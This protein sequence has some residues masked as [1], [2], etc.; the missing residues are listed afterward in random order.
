M[1]DLNV[2]EYN[3]ALESILRQEAEKCRGYAWLHN[4]CEAIY[5]RYHNTLLIPTIILSTITGATSMSS[6]SLFAG[7]EKSASVGLGAVAILVGILNTLGGTFAF[8]KRAEGH[9]ISHL[10]YSK[11]YNHITIELALPRKSRMRPKDFLKMVRQ[12]TER[13]AETSP[14]INPAVIDEFNSRFKEYKQVAKPEITNGL[15]EV[16]IFIE[17]N[18]AHQTRDPSSV[19]SFHTALPPPPPVLQRSLTLGVE[20]TPSVDESSGRDRTAHVEDH[21]TAPSP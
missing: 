19:G 2:A 15:S 4:R 21:Q 6:S 8:S 20:T 9:R 3:P 11:L 12:T 1:E 14:P 7:D 5:S 10:T 17:E 16:K 18:P 13:L